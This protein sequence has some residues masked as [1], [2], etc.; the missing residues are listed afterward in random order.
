MWEIQILGTDVYH[1]VQ[2]F[3]IYSILG[4][5]VE[6][7]YMSFC[8]K[9]WTN[10]GF[11]HGP[12]CPIYGVGALTVYFILKPF[13]H[14]YIILY[15]CGTI[16]ATTLEY[17]TAIIMQKIFGCIWWDYNDKPFN[18]KGILCLESSIAWG[19]YT[20][21]LFAFLHKWANMILGLY[22]RRTGEVL[23]TILIVY[24]IVDF[25]ISL[26]GAIDLNEKL[27]KLSSIIDEIQRNLHYR[28]IHLDKKVIR[29][30]LDNEPKEN[31][32]IQLED[33]NLKKLSEQYTKERSHNFF[34]SKHFIKSYQAFRV[35]GRKEM[36][37]ENC[38]EEE[39][40]KAEMEVKERNS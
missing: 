10:R 14:N 21:F 32:K 16:L 23:A 19:F 13:S 22:S 29:E 4:W 12:I 38:Q 27:K 20:I 35:W 15:F 31:E 34:L 39:I 28:N 2:W 8:N 6:S 40:V 9:K 33:K 24:Y 7:I 1:I 37:K 36:E 25:I 18:Y 26:I 11:I 30:K 3:F 17:I 5:V